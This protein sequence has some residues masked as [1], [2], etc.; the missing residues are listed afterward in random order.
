M[1]KADPKERPT[2]LIAAS[3]PALKPRYVVL[4]PITHRRPT[5]KTVGIEIPQKVKRA[6]GLDDDPSWVI[7]SE[8]NVD[9]WP[10]AGLAPLPGS[11]GDF[12]YGFLPPGL[13]AIIRSRFLELARAGESGSVR[14]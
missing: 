11:A 12:T 10:N 2:C 1:P 13:F 9:E 7:I 5:G 3:D 8:H 6:I 4:L 14:R